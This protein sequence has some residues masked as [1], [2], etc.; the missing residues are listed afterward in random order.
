MGYY[1][2]ISYKNL[3]VWT[4]DT[5][6]NETFNFHS[7]YNIRLGLHLKRCVLFVPPQIKHNKNR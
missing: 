7:L 5:I 3:K 6:Y 2:S 1:M 4:T